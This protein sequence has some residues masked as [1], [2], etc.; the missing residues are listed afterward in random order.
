MVSTSKAAAAT[1]RML[2][3]KHFP[4]AEAAITEITKIIRETC[5]N[6]KVVDKLIDAVLEDW[7]E[8]HGPKAFR[9][10]AV[11]MN[12]VNHQWKSYD[13]EL[14]PSCD[15]CNDFGYDPIIKDRCDCALGRGYSEAI[16]QFRKR[17]D[18]RSEVMNR[19]TKDRKS[20]V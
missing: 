5:A 4:M 2:I 8:W 20:V 11:R 14:P 1:N 12:S 18:Q 6:D 10:T 9:E 15:K 19:T 7:N 17:M 16:I 3:L 13:K